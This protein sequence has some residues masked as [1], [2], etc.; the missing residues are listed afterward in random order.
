MLPCSYGKSC[1]AIGCGASWIVRIVLVVIAFL[2]M[3]AAA[4][5]LCEKISEARM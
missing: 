5:F 2:L 3:L 1:L 4:G